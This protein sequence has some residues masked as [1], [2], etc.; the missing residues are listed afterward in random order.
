MASFKA[1]CPHCGTRSVLFQSNRD[2][3]SQFD[4]ISFDVFAQCNFCNRGIIASYKIY[5]LDVDPN[6]TRPWP[7]PD[8]IFPSAADTGTLPHTPEKV[9]GFYRQGMENLPGNPDAAGAMFRKTLETT[10][11]EK[12]PDRG[13]MPL[14]VS[15]K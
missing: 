1:D 15:P 3:V 2:T 12:F 8:E 14:G 9:T 4:E 11:I 7:P 13:K 10:L 6:P 5:T